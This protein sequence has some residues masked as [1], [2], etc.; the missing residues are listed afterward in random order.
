MLVAEPSFMQTLDEKAVQVNALPTTADPLLANLQNGTD[1]GLLAIDFATRQ[2]MRLNGTAVTN[3]AGFIIQATQ[4]YGNCPK[5]IQ[6]R[7]LTVQA[8]SEKRGQSISSPQLS[9]AQRQWIATADTF[10][11]ASAHPEGGLDASHRGGN[12][13]F[14]H[15]QNPT[16]LIWPDYAGNMMF[17]TLGNIAANPNVGL[18]FLDFAGNRT[19][20]LTGRAEIVWDKKEVAQFVGAERL[21]TFAVQ[22][23]IETRTDYTFEWTFGSYSPH[24]PS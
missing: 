10:F 18:L 7:Y 14:V 6:E 8:Q 2:R 24:N 21:V 22:R 4:V 11:I 1:I 9:A 15:V 5:Y 23:V 20:Q 12:G 19:L 13:G 3:N 16:Q 17:N